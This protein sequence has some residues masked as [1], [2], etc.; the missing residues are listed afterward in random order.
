MKP[1]S[2]VY[3]AQLLKPR[4]GHPT[5][6]VLICTITRALPNGTYR[7]KHPS[8]KWGLVAHPAHLAHT[9]ADAQRKLTTRI[10]REIES[11]VTAIRNLKSALHRHNATATIAFPARAGTSPMRP[12]PHPHR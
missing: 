8:T 5:A 4:A 6:R 7:L 3:Y 9:P 2:T 11:H 1:D 12:P 10:G